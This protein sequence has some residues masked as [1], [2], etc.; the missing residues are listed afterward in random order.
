MRF[1]VVV[2]AYNEEKLLGEDGAVPMSPI[3]FY[4]YVQLER[5]SV[6]DTL[7]VNLLDQTDLTK[8]VVTEG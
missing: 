7:N 2:P 6:Q 3:Y 8:V 5:P 4:T 1:S